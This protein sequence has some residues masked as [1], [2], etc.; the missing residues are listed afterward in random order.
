[1]KIAGKKI[2]KGYF[3]VFMSYTTISICLIMLISLV[4]ANRIN[5]MTKKGLYTDNYNSFYICNAKNQ[6]QWN[7][8][9]PDLSAKYDDFALYTDVPDPSITVRGIYVKGKVSTP[10]IVYGKYFDEST[11]W[12]DIP[13][14]VLGKEYEK[15][16]I[17]KDGRKYYDYFG[18]NCEVIGIMGTEID[19]RINYMIM[20]DMKTAIKFSDINTSYVYDSANPDT[21]YN[22][23]KY[24]SEV[25]PYPA[26]VDII[27]E[28]ANKKF[29]L[30]DYLFSGEVIMNTMY[31]MMLAS[32]MVSTL[33]VTIIWFRRRYSLICVWNMCGYK[34][35]Y[36]IVELAKRYYLIAGGGFLSG[37]IISGVCGM[38]IRSINIAAADIIYAFGGTIGI[39]TVILFVCS[40]KEGRTVTGSARK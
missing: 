6:E 22:V 4:R 2:P 15:Y 20:M 1:M 37:F 26:E 11:S 19:S 31:V 28:E 40:M 16:V 17:E 13:R 24:I 3:L 25:F 7:D 39:G 29:F 9:I 30:I 33:L 12:T 14:V 23:G 35:L 18:I 8:I 10:P 27:L 5:D 36:K 38:Y 34:N 32:F 21:V